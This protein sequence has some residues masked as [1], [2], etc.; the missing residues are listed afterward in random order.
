MPTVLYWVHIMYSSYVAICE[1]QIII[2]ANVALNKPIQTRVS[3]RAVELAIYSNVL[4][5]PDFSLIC[6][7]LAGKLGEVCYGAI[8]SRERNTLFC[9]R[10]SMKHAF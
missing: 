2:K 1:V 6:S 5:L 9:C 10:E 8:T 4:Y 3:K 7:T